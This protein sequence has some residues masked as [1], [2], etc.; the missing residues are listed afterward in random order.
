MSRK[1]FKIMAGAKEIDIT[2]AMGVQ[3]SGDIGRKRSAEFVT[4]PIYVK[5]LVLSG[6]QKTVCIITMDVL[7]VDKST[8]ETIRESIHRD[9]GIEKDAVLV[10]ALQNHSAPSVGRI[11][12]SEYFESTDLRKYVPEDCPWL[13]GEE[14]AYTEFVIAQTLAAAASAYENMQEVFL[15]HHRA[16]D[17]RVAV[18]RRYVM[19]DGTV[20]GEPAHL[21]PNILY[22]EGPIDPEIGII[23]MQNDKLETVAMILNYAMHPC[24]GY[25]HNY[26][27]ADWPGAWARMMKQHVGQSC[28]PI[29][30]N[31]FCGN[32][33]NMNPLDPDQDRQAERLRFKKADD[34][35]PNPHNWGPDKEISARKL[36]ESTMRALSQYYLVKPEPYTLQEGSVDYMSEIMQIPYRTMSEELVEQARELLESFSEPD[37]VDETKTAVKWEWHYALSRLDL[38]NMIAK[39]KAFDYK[40]Q[41]LKIC[42][43]A[44]VAV[45]GEPF[46]EGQL[47]IKKRC[48]GKNI[49]AAH[50]CHHYAGY[51]P[52]E[53]ALSGSGYETNM[54][55]GSKLYAGALQDVVDKAVELVDQLFSNA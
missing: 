2:P 23:L 21:D 30:I 27:S 4:D 52:T 36:T 17:G 39:T 14:K 19:R 34:N 29:V 15:S 16:I 40:V 35:M 37:W 9:Y 46:I 50:M 18:N 51:L 7:A 6:G 38:V 48:S 28:V 5:V 44:L 8:C 24:A 32:L 22:C 43:T 11:S 42:D 10:H 26:I 41:V 12:S 49:I 1:K 3:I 45:A 31:G 13:F 20:K 25:N 33:V 53:R 47:E 54:S 55:M